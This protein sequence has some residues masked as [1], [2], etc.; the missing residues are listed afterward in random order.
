MKFRKLLKFLFRATKLQKYSQKCYVLA[1]FS[2]CV[3]YIELIRTYACDC[4]LCFTSNWN[5]C[6]FFFWREVKE[7]RSIVWWELSSLLNNQSSWQS[8]L[9]EKFYKCTI[10]LNI[11][12]LRWPHRF[13]CVFR[14]TNKLDFKRVSICRICF[15]SAV[16]IMATFDGY[17]NCKSRNGNTLIW[18]E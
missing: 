7:R 13:L 3:N 8:D 17:N 18:R 9:T 4:N 5:E 2:S 16:L 12:I 14:K 11:L 15:S 1:K 10:F 6:I